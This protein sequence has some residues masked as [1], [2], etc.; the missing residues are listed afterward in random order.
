MTPNTQVSMTTHNSATK[1]PI[2]GPRDSLQMRRPVL[3]EIEDISI[4]NLR[5]A[6]KPDTRASLLPSP[7]MFD[8]KEN[9]WTAVLGKRVLR[10]F[11]SSTFRDMQ[12]ERDEF[13]KNAEKK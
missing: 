1:P 6:K 8:G 7:T 4:G 9:K 12:R 2:K 13:F 10:V 3:E 11:M 5:S